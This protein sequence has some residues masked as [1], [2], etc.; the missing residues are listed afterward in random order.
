METLVDLKV[1]GDLRQGLRI[2]L[3][4][5]NEGQYPTLDT[6]GVI[7]PSPAL[8]DL[9]D[10]WRDACQIL[11]TAY[12]A[13]H[14]KSVHYHGYISSFRRYS[15]LAK[16]VAAE[17]QDWFTSVSFRELDIQLRDVLSPK[18]SIRVLIRASDRY[19]HQLPWHLWDLFNQYPTADVMFS[20][21]QS[22]TA[23]V[24]PPSKTTKVRILLVLGDRTGIDLDTDLKLLSQLP[25]TQITPLIEP[26]Q[27]EFHEHLY[28]QAWDILFFAGHSGTMEGQ[29]WLQLNASTQL[30]LDDIRYGLRRAIANGLTL[31]IFNSCD[32][33]GL[34]SA[35]SDLQLPHLIVMREAIP[36][37]IAQMFLSYF[38]QAFSQGEPLH[39]AVRTARE[40]L[41][42]L[43]GQ[44][45]CASWLPA[46]YQHPTAAPLEWTDLIITSQRPSPPK[47]KVSLVLRL[48][49][50]I[51]IALGVLGLQEFGLLQRGALYGYDQLLRL[52]PPEILP[53]R[54][55]I[56]GVTETDLNTYGYPLPDQILADAIAQL[57]EKGARTI[58]IDLFRDRPI[59][60]NSDVL[61]NQF[62][63]QPSLFGIC[64]PEEIGDI[65]RPGIAPPPRL[66]DDRVGFSSIVPDPDGILRRHLLFMHTEDRQCTTTYALSSHLAFHYLASEGITPEELPNQGLKL[67]QASLYPLSENSGGYRGLDDRGFQIML[68]YADIEAIADHVTLPDLLAGDID[69]SLIQDRIVLIGLV[70]DNSSSTDLFHTPI[71]A[72]TWPV[73]PIPGVHIHA[74]MT[75]HLVSMALGERPQIRLWSWWQEVLWVVSWSIVAGFATYLAARPLYQGLIL[76]GILVIFIASA[77][78]FLLMGFWVPLV[79]GILALLLSGL[80]VSLRLERWLTLVSDGSNHAD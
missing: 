36:D 67:G 32:G 12:R 15:K 57:D 43:E 75:S 9:L 10:Q 77:Y 28:D 52:R 37:A 76:I 6:Y 56:V 48:W 8:A 74:Q 68:N 25:S 13:I 79:P 49:I 64:S 59:G 26:S 23:V 17:V 27:Q 50:A 38:L 72:Y 3:S 4:V 54:F 16:Q 14:P 19:L 73:R 62:E 11:T 40:K 63:L 55:A 34:A 42:G 35:L 20:P 80:S 44:F 7:P 39:L 60:D 18:S 22:R 69:P 29:G 78:G 1:D 66:P 46:L 45:P 71:S 53:Q 21:M 70:A 24:Q 41:E 31:A 47:H 61:V 58:G 2:F 51:G 33:L 65:N 5:S 30:N